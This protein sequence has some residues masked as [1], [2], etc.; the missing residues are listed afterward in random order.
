MYKMSN[1][2]FQKEVENGDVVMYNSKTGAVVT[3]EKEN[4]GLVDNILKIPDDFTDHEYFVPLSQNGFIIDNE[5]NEYNDIKAK[6]DSNFFND[7]LINIVMLPAEFCNFTCPYCF[8]YNYKNKTMSESV[9]KN[10]KNYIRKQTESFKTTGKKY[11][12]RITW[13]GGEPLLK[14]DRIFTFMDEL[15]SEFDDSCNIISNIVTN[16][17]ELSYDVFN[18]LFNKGITNFQVTFDG[19]KE[20]HDQLR[21]LKNG[22]GSYD[23][24]INNL[25][26]IVKN[27]KQDDKF[28]F[29][30]RINFL[31]NT[32]EKIF[33]LI[34]DLFEIFGQDKHFTVYCRPVY[35]FATKRDD[36]NQIKSNIFSISDG[37]T[38]QNV[39]S[40]YIA[41]KAHS[42]K[43][44]RMINDYLPL[45]TVSWCSEDNTYSTIIGSDGSIYICDS[46][47]GDENVCVGKLQDG[48]TIN[49]NDKSRAWRKSVFEYENFDECNKCKCLP[50]CVGSCKRE[51]IEG[52]AKPCLWTESDILE[53]MENYY[54]AH[55]SD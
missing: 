31:K 6:Y 45:P 7:R 3:V 17:Y 44:Y 16:G 54:L 29:A 53:L 48:G 34:D 49:Y 5:Y 20:N 28:S 11:T 42:G 4:K 12:L 30:I 23:M 10:I 52:I 39:F 55:C 41:Q 33:G 14:K 26:D 22:Q 25:K 40:Q 13:F 27:I 8:I 36:I 21:K 51:R 32:Y 24:I 35:N 46:L 50:I 2:I 43:E 18:R 1:Y 47:V 9:Y 19:A 37:L 15:H 38:I